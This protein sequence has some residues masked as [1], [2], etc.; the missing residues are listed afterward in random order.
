M[1]TECIGIRICD[2]GRKEK[3]LFVNIQPSNIVKL[4]KLSGWLVPIILGILP[5]LIGVDIHEYWQGRPDHEHEEKERKADVACGIRNQAN[6]KRA[7]EGARLVNVKGQY[8]M[9]KD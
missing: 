2:S 9:L 1:P 4:S 5:T 7:D 6:H 3:K 8:K